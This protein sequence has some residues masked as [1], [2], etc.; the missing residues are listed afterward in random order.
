[1]SMC[2]IYSLVT[3]VNDLFFLYRPVWKCNSIITTSPA[4]F[5]HAFPPIVIC[6]V[7]HLSKRS[8]EGFAA[9]IPRIRDMKRKIK[10]NSVE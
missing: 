4:T 7:R 3:I 5:T 1:M 9:Y 10:I 6:H 2:F 8:E